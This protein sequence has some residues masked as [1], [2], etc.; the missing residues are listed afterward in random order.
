MP[1]RPIFALVALAVPLCA[2]L[3]P[4]NRAGVSAGHIHIYA[5]DLEAQR[6]FWTDLGGTEVDGRIEIPGIYIVLRQQ[7]PT[8]GSVGSVVDHIGFKVKEI[9]ALLPKW[10]AAGIKVDPGTTP[11]RRFVTAPDNVKV[12]IMED[13]SLSTQVAMYHIHM[14]MPDSKATQAWYVKYFGAVPAERPSGNGK[15]RFLT[16]TV[17]GAEFTITQK[18]SLLAPTKGRSLEH[19]GFEVENI[20]QFVKKLEDAGIKTEMGVHKSSNS[21]VR[22]AHITDPW[23]V[24]IELTEGLRSVSARSGSR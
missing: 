21:N 10:K 8:A 11:T 3:A 2:Q 23:G 24:R 6:R 13:P 16:A 15:N 14:F 17:P 18:E 22:V 4:P 12:E 19:I 20:D 5:H 9:N 7:D 1:L